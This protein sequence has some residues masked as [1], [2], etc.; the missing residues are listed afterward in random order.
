MPEY[1]PL[2]LPDNPKLAGNIT[3]FARA[4]RRAGLPIGPGRVIDAIRAVEAAGF[5]EKRDFY[6]TLHAVFVNRHRDR[7][8]FDQAF[9]LFWRNPRLLERMMSLV[10]PRFRDPGAEESE[11][12]RRRLSEALA[13][14]TPPPHAPER[15][16]PPEI[17]FDARLTWSDRE[18]LQQ[19]DFEQMTAAEIEQAKAAIARMRLPLLELRTRRFR[20]DPRGARVDMRATLRGALRSGRLWGRTVHLGRFAVM[21]D[22]EGPTIGRPRIEDHP[23]GQRLLLP[24]RDE[25]SGVAEINAWLNGAPISLLPVESQPTVKRWPA[26]SS[27]WGVVHWQFP[28]TWGAGNN[29]TT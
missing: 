14:D 16:E 19:K 21:R 15:D 28:L 1:A 12:L 3:H 10:L 23:A 5:T 9:H 2:D 29:V 8:I 22:V 6:W 11:P 24:V 25:G 13:G 7:E 27:S 26:M 18:L 4:L 20:S 17:E